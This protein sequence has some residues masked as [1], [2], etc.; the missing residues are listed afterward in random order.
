M[1]SRFLHSLLDVVNWQFTFGLKAI[2][3]DLSICK[4]NGEQGEV[5]LT[6]ASRR[7]I[8]QSSRKQTQ[9]DRSRQVRSFWGQ[10][11]P[12]QFRTDSSACW[13]YL[14]PPIYLKQLFKLGHCGCVRFSLSLNTKLP[15]K[16]QSCRFN[17]TLLRGHQGNISVNIT[18]VLLLR[19]QQYTTI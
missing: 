2:S 9:I 19:R 13:V 7:L 4:K 16:K 12:G 3:T 17:L 5:F 15:S 8:N 1:K 6:P 11:K 18:T 14:C 10:A